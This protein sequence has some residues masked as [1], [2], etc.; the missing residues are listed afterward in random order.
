MGSIVAILLH[1]TLYAIYLFAIALHVLGIYLLCS[2]NRVK[3]N[4]RIFL[5]NLSVFEI[6]MMCA[7]VIHSVSHIVHE[8]ELTIYSSITMCALALSW[9]TG[10]ML[11]TIDRFLEVK[12]NIKYHLYVTPQRIRMALIST[13]LYA[14]LNNTWMFYVQH[15]KNF[16]LLKFIYTTLFPVFEAGFIITCTIVYTYIFIKLNQNQ[17]GRNRVNRDKISTVVK[18]CSG[19]N[20]NKKMSNFVPFYIIVTFLFFSGVPELITTIVV[21]VLEIEDIYIEL[22]TLLLYVIGYITDAVIYIFLLRQLRQLLYR[23]LSS[24]RVGISRQSRTDT[25]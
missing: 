8:T 16:Y 12:L 6:A 14:V 2:T 7:Q 22:A 10:L 5:I 4:Q 13:W 19:H 24:N 23:K 25:E 18:Q 21:F 11:M 15:Y 1:L 3:E 9:A 20:N 17:K